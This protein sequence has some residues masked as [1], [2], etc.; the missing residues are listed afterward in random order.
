MNEKIKEIM[1]E[2]NS[3][4]ELGKPFWPALEEYSEIFAELLLREFVKVAG[5]DRSYVLKHFGI[6]E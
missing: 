1:K 2:A 4:I 3:Q 6:D 5:E